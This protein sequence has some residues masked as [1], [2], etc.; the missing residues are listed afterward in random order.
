MIVKLLSTRRIH[1]FRFLISLQNFQVVVLWLLLFPNV[2]VDGTRGVVMKLY[3][4]DALIEV[5]MVV[6]EVVQ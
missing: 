4:R 5:V 3:Y 6:V 1:P 2:S